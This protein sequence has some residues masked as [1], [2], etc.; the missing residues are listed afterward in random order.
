MVGSFLFMVAVATQTLGFEVGAIIRKIDADKRVAVVFANGKE[1]TVK[2]AGDVKIE[3]AHGEELPA[4]L[5]ATELAEGATV[6]IR[7]ELNANMPTMCRSV[8]EESCVP[9]PGRILRVISRS[10]KAPLASSR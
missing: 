1:R 6:T 9:R 3:D 4:G 10:A 8:W 2:I 5:G 7:V